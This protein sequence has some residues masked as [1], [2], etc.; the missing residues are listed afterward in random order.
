MQYLQT[1]LGCAGLAGGSGNGAAMVRACIEV[2]D[3]DLKGDDLLDLLLSI[4]SDVPF[5]FEGGAQRVQG[6]GDI[7]NPVMSPFKYYLIINPGI[8]ISTQK[9][10]RSWD[11]QYWVTGKIHKVKGERDKV[12]EALDDYTKGNIPSFTLY[13]AF[14]RSLFPS[15]LTLAK[16]KEHLI[17]VGA[18]Q[19]LMTGSGSTIFGTFIDE[20]VCRHACEKLKNLYPFVEIAHDVDFGLLIE[21]T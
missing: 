3:L 18:T 16:I 4:G 11:D 9:A 2:F 20:D 1:D 8:H 21:A 7:L 5:C 6:T 14:E 19:S 10:Y 12:K 13:N 15:Y 17:D